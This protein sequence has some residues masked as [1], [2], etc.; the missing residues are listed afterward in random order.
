MLAAAHE[1]SV[2]ADK[3]GQDGGL[4][5]AN[6]RAV[7]GGRSVNR[8]LGDTVKKA[9]GLMF[10]VL[11][12]VLLIGRIA[13]AAEIV[14]ERSA[15]ETLV[16][17]SLFQRQGRYYLQEG[18]CYAYLESPTVELRAGRV[19][20]RSHLSAQMG[21]EMQ[22]IC[23]GPAFVSWTVVSGQAGHDGG[24]LRLTGLRVDEVEGA[25]VSA[26][27]ESG[28]LPRLPELV[29]L[30]V[31]AAVRTMLVQTTGGLRPTLDRFEITAVGAEND[32]LT[33]RFDFVLRAQ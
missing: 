16:K 20:I 18:P 31:A 26:L 3:R 14:L 17:A 11:A 27:L 24:R 33:V 32:R 5:L 6:L 13:P 28:L 29:N 7:P 2:P 8:G 23:I 25:P 1:L 12:S 19:R 22:G 10:W 4:P 21:L 9:T 30:D 15:V